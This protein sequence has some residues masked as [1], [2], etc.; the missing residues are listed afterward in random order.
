MELA[1]LKVEIAALEEELHQSHLKRLKSGK[2]TIVAGLLYGDMIASFGKIA[3]LCY[4]IVNHK[5]GIT[6]E[7]SRSSH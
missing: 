4:T 5:K 6:H 2:C 7:S 1:R 3:Q